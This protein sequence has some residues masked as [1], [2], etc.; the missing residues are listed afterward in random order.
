MS[1]MLRNAIWPQLSFLQELV[2][3]S[4]SIQALSNQA[5]QILNLV[6][7]GSALPHLACGTFCAPCVQGRALDEEERRELLRLQEPPR[8]GSNMRP[9]LVTQPIQKRLEKVSKLYFPI[10]RR[11]NHG[12]RLQK[13]TTHESQKN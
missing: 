3:A 4:Y 9:R 5:V 13:P 10:R 12:R 1:V 6:A 7:G 11:P 2:R 8:R